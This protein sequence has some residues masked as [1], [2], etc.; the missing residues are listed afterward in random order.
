MKTKLLIIGSISAILFSGCSTSVPDFIPTY[1][2]QKKMNY[3]EVNPKHSEA[4]AKDF[5]TVA[6]KTKSDPNYTRMGL[7]Q[8]DKKWFKTITYMLWN[9][10]LSKQ[11][12]INEGLTRYPSH[13][14]E[15]AFVADNI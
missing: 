1:K 10:N 15:F 14:Y 13:R 6:L 2:V 11:D 3:I 8:N 5:N 12:Y 9:R 7:K 4:F